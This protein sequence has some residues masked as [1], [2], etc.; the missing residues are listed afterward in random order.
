MIWV[1]RAFWSSGIVEKETKFAFVDKELLTIFV[2]VIIRFYLL[3]A[4]HSFY[5]TS[6]ARP[7]FVSYSINIQRMDSTDFNESRFTRYTSS[8]VFTALTPSNTVSC[9]SSLLLMRD[10]TVVLI[11]VQS[12]F[13]SYPHD[14][15]NERP[16]IFSTSLP[17][18]LMF[19]F[20]C[21][22]RRTITM[23]TSSSDYIQVD[24]LSN[25]SWEKRTRLAL[26]RKESRVPNKQLQKTRQTTMKRPYTTTW[27][28]LSR[29]CTRWN[30]S[31]GR[32][33]IDP[34]ERFLF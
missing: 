23:T 12:C 19:L 25:P 21:C 6:I 5:L 13:V 3:E 14:H 2:L 31:T 20:P 1:I 17:S 28:P 11:E 9:Y 26:F 18:R 32:W 24:H 15:C 33:W 27:P 16:F 22:H 30:V 29:S 34:V 8:F 10:S 7:S 4:H